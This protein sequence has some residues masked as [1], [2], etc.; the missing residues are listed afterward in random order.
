MQKRAIDDQ[1]FY[2]VKLI[3]PRG[4]AAS[5]LFAFNMAG[6]ITG[7]GVTSLAGD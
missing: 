4:D 5:V 3:F 6:K 2:L 1:I 7:I